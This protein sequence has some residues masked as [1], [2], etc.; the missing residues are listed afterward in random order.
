VIAVAIGYLLLG[1]GFPAFLMAMAMA[2]LCGLPACISVRMLALIVLR[3]APRFSG[4]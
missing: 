3:L 4:I 1:L 2:C